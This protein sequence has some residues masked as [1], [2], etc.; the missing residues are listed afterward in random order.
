MINS[1]KNNPKNM[2]F[3]EG[4]RRRIKACTIHGMELFPRE[5]EREREIEDVTTYMY[6]G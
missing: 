6:C 3:E 1:R 5:R 2:K 4:E